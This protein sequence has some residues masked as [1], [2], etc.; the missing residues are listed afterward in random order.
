MNMTLQHWICKKI[1]SD[2]KDKPYFGCANDMGNSIIDVLY[3]KE[4]R[5][6][7]RSD[8]TELYWLSH[9]IAEMYIWMYENGEISN[10]DIMATK[11]YISFKELIFYRFDYGEVE[12]SKHYMPWMK[13]LPYQDWYMNQEEYYNEEY[14]LLRLWLVKPEAKSFVTFINDRIRYLINSNSIHPDF[15]KD[16]GDYS[17]YKKDPVAYSIKLYEGSYKQDLVF[18]QIRQ[19][20]A[21]L[22]AGCYGRNKK[23]DKLIDSRL[24]LFTKHFLALGN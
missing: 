18:A 19:G 8:S 3:W 21:L 4:Q 5:L 10:E 15:T 20:F 17:D 9:V 6:N 16:L 12:Y 7:R 1:N 23:I 11:I 2:I 24:E 22:D 14:K 13:T